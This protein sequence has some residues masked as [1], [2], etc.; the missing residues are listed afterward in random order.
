MTSTYAFARTCRE[1]GKNRKPMQGHGMMTFTELASV[2]SA[3]RY[4]ATSRD[5]QGPPGTR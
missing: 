3:G 1:R 4:D 5:S 2:A